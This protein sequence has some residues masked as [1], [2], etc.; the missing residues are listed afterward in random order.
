MWRAQP[1]GEY[2]LKL[3]RAN[4]R[5]VWR[6][7]LTLQE[8]LILVSERIEAEEQTPE[9]RYLTATI[10]RHAMPVSLSR[11]FPPRMRRKDLSPEDVAQFRTLD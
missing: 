11:Y 10:Y 6:T 1:V 8:A 5:P 9:P 7:G 2:G 4:E 3:H